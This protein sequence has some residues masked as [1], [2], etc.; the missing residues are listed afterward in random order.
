MKYP[1]HLR[2]CWGNLALH[3]DE[4]RKNINGCYG[5]SDLGDSN[6]LPVCYSENPNHVST[7]TN[8]MSDTVVLV[9]NLTR[10]ANLKESLNE[11][12]AFCGPIT[13]LTLQYVHSY[14]YHSRLI[15]KPRVKKQVTLWSLSPLEQ[16]PERLFS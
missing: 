4:K 8:K 14:R 11:F 6:I 3:S 2:V 7:K 10:V 16:L 12:L 5:F 1:Y 15:A 9:E 13:K